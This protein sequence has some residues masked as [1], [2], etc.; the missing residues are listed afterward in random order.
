MLKNMKGR[1][2]SDGGTP[3]DTLSHHFFNVF[4][5]FPKKVFESYV[6]KKNYSI[7][8]A[9]GTNRGTLVTLEFNVNKSC[10]RDYTLQSNTVTLHCTGL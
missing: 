2:L 8:T 9:V 4:S 1:A 5:T 7:E 10:S 6:T 3:S